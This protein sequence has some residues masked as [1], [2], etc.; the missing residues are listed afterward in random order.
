MKS[1]VLL[2][3]GNLATHLFDAINN[4][5]EFE[6]IQVYNRNKKSLDYYSS[7]VETTSSLTKIK[8]AAIYIIA[9]PDDAIKSFS[10][11][12]PFKDNLVV[13]TSGSVAMEA[14]SNKNRKGV[15]YPLQTFSKNSSINFSEIPICIEASNPSDTLLLKKLGDSISN[16]VIELTSNEREKIHLSAVIVNNFVNYLYQVGNDLLEEQALPFDLLKPLI[17]ETAKKI[18]HLTPAEAQTGPAKR[19]DKKTIE[20][21]LHLLNDSPYEELYQNLTNAILKKYNNL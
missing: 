1:I 9:V 6:V 4:L 2:G 7:T 11:K 19:N 17:L 18:E 16:K 20:K 10:G 5:T 8:K 14:L 3:A 15:I 12:L 13:H 21:H